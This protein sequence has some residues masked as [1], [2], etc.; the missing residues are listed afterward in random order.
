[1]ASVSDDFEKV[2]V[3]LRSGDRERLQSYY[4][5]AGYNRVIRELVA[6]HLKELDE[7]L[8]RTMNPGDL[9]VQLPSD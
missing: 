9:D 7:R 3:R 6:R 5:T 1:M 2:C 4:P 8:S